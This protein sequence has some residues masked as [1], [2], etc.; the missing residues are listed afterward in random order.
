MRISRAGSET[1]DRASPAS[2]PPVPLR[3]PRQLALENLALRQHLAVYKGRVPRPRLRI[4]DR[5]LWVGLARVWTG[6]RRALTETLPISSG[7]GEGSS[8]V[9]HSRQPMS[10]R[11]S[12]DPRAMADAPARWRALRRWLVSGVAP[13]TGADFDVERRALARAE[14]PEGP[15]PITGRRR[16]VPQPR[17]RA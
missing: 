9:V 7:V 1:R 14:A 8:D 6:W 5:L 13:M 3:R 4:M 10:H 2:T 17:R 11:R 16:G 15:R 12:H